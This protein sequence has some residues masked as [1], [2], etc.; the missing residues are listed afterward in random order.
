MNN[1]VAKIL[2]N[3]TIP[4]AKPLPII[5]LL[6]VSGTM[7]ENGKI[8]QLNNAVRE[9]IESF[10]DNESV[11][12]KIQVAVIT[13]GGTS[14]KLHLGLTDADK[15]KWTD[16]TAEGLTPMGDALRI[17]KEMIEDRNV[18]SNTYRPTVILIS[19]GMPNDT[20]WE[21]QMKNFTQD[22]RS[23]KCVRMAMGVGVP[24]GTNEYEVLKSFVGD[25]EMIF[26]SDAAADIKKFFQ[27]VTF[28][29]NQL[30]RS[31]NIE[32]TRQ[33]MPKPSE[34]KS[35]LGDDDPFGLGSMI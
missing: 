5:L 35:I 10:S 19:D 12:A 17:A 14:A 28:T 9:M 30:S 33:S 34:M 26:S 29:T 25:P 27:Y 6:D 2:S 3:V 13:F 16:M 1:D 23:S 4:T 32:E 18:I 22:G 11:L 20:G 7:S 15:I 8:V 24:A 31:N 21:N